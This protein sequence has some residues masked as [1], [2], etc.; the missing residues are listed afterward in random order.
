MRSCTTLE[1]EE[2]EEEHDLVD[3]EENQYT[4]S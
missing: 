1:E 2:E 4:F 3:G